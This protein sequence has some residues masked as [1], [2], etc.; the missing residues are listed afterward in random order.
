MF[1]FRLYRFQNF[2]DY[3]KNAPNVVFIY[4]LFYY[5]LGTGLGLT[6]TGVLIITGQYF[7]K[8][9]AFANGFAH[10]GGGGG[11]FLFSP[12]VRY[13]IDEY[14]WRG[15]MFILAGLCL[16][17]FVIMAF[18]R[19]LPP[20]LVFQQPSNEDKSNNRFCDVLRNPKVLIICLST[21]LAGASSS[22]VY[23]LIADYAEFCGTS[24]FQVSLLYSA[25]GITTLIGKFFTGL[26]SNSTD[27]DGGVLFFGT[28]SIVAFCTWLIPIL[29][30]SYSGQMAF[31]LLFGTYN[32]GPTILWSSL[33][34]NFLPLEQLG[35]GIGIILTIQGVGQLLGPVISGRME[36]E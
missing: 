17:I 26:A 36:N 33:P 14:T 34:A 18:M 1:V 25:I 11:V 35:T 10:T 4:Y 32:S 30:R 19:P 24:H 16:H 5:I 22:A 28:L 15:S 31:A 3:S 21:L 9:R 29:F 2:R 6:Y 12:L 8:R 23:I 7:D 20:D 13:L 27:V